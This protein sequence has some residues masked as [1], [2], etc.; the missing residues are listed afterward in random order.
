M[1]LDDFFE[2][3]PNHG[4]LPLHHFFCGFH[5]RA[6]TALFE[7][8]I[9]EGFEQLERHLF[10]QTALMEMQ[11]GTNDDYRTAGVIDALSQQVLAESALLTFE[12]VGERFQR[13]VVRTAQNTS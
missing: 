10:R 5:R 13:A 1:I 9:D 8:V 7:P 11:L 2:N 12:R 3:V 4:V 6:M